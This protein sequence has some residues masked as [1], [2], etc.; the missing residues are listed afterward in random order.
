MSYQHQTWDKLNG[1]SVVYCDVPKYA[2]GNLNDLWHTRRL[3]IYTQY[4]ATPANL[5]N[6]RMYPSA[7]KKAQIP[8]SVWC[9]NVSTSAACSV[10]VS[11]AV[12]KVSKTT[13]VFVD[14]GAKVDSNYIRQENGVNWRDIM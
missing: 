5:Q 13:V 2:L 12:S 7:A 4:E 3:F 6:D 8:T 11:V 1:T 14:P 10:M 9:V